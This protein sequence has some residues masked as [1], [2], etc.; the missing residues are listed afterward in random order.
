MDNIF[1]VDLTN[2]DREPI[3]TPGSIQQHGFLI[4]IHPETLLIEQLS[5]NIESF[6]GRTA[7]ELL[8]KSIQEIEA[9][10]RISQQGAVLM[11]LL[12]LG[13]RT[14]NYEGLNPHKIAIGQQHFFT[15]IHEH[16]NRIILE[17]E[18]IQ[19]DDASITLQ[20]SM[21]NALN[22][23]QSA[24]TQTRLLNEV[25]RLVKE[26]SGY[27][28][29]MIYKFH[30]DFHGEV[31]AESIDENKESWLHLHYPASDIPAQAR[32]L[33][34]LNLVR[35]IADVHG[36]PSALLS[37]DE[38]A[39]PLDL[40]HSGLRAVS[41]IHIEYLK[42]MGVGA[43]FSVS[44]VSKGELWGLIACHNDEPRVIDYNS[45]M[46]CKFIGQLFSAAL[47]FKSNEELDKRNSLFKDRQLRLFEQVMKDIDLV[48][49]LMQQEVNLLDINSASGAVLCFENGLHKKGETPDENEI[50][51]IIEW[52]KKKN[53]TSF[54]Q[55]SSLPL[56]YEGAKKIAGLAS[57]IMA[58]EISLDWSEFIIWFKPEVV[59]MV[60]WAGQQQ[61]DASPQEDGSIRISPRKSFAKWTQEVKY[62]SDDWSSSEISTALKLREDVIHAA[63]KKANEIRKLNEL[64]KQAYD[65]LDT[66]SFT[67][68]HDLRT[69]LSSIKNYS[70]IILED[71]GEEL[72]D[73][74]KQMFL[75]IIKGTNKM[76]GLI[77]DVLHY[78]RVGR[79]EINRVPL[80]M[81][82][83]LK[84][85]RE[86]ILANYPGKDIHFE[87]LETPS[88]TGD[89]TM[90]LQ[91]FTN[92][93]N[94]AVK[95]STVNSRAKVTVNGEEKEGFIVYKITDNG[96]GI[97]MKYASRIFELFQ[98]LDNAQE[99]E[100]TGVGLAIAKR[101]VEKHNGK[102]WLESILNSGTQFYIALPVNK[103]KDA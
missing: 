95:Y 50:N 98:R 1:K 56:E 58:A 85:V 101:I 94:N 92:L 75:K 73:K 35:I 25:A 14:G 5:A 20:K 89:K 48:N 97:D 34:K 43:S 102:I 65:A 41:P 19:N 26:I 28:R 30:K 11:D 80:N 47:E 57:G 84:D 103:S 87:L 63:N 42:N 99:I 13:K 71:Y 15:I 100:G 88:V 27:S 64:L 31:V 23:I 9:N 2:C 18:A 74:A 91:L 24:T 46:A 77:K 59:K 17:F 68:S 72:S 62:T 69:P 37:N 45:R 60:N 83:M 7:K 61:K 10:S 8:G 21:S 79:A 33:Y 55:T 16:N 22:V 93:L 90:I 39:A 12:K 96:I 76:A 49:G 38:S 78:T 40:T 4:A 6:T 70:E 82:K 86:E 36:E 67:I 66:F 3:H 54:F 51:N 52:L 44:L 81:A 29:I 32:E 53:K